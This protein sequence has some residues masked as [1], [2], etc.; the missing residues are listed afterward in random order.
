MTFMTFSSHLEGYL[1][2][3]HALIVTISNAYHF[4]H[5]ADDIRRCILLQYARAKMHRSS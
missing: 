2:I 4:A 5:L 1:V 3:T